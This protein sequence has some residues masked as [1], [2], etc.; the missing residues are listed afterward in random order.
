LKELDDQYQSRLKTLYSDSTTISQ[1]LE[2]ADLIIGAVLIPGKLAPKVLT[3]E[4][5]KKAA[6]GSVFVD[7]AI[8]QGGCS[9][10]SRPTTHSNPTYVEEGVVHYCVANMPGACARTATLALTHATYKYAC[11]IANKGY[12]EALLRH[13]GLMEGLNVCEGKVTNQPVAQDLGHHYY[14]PKECLA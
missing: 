1:L 13:P 7:V 11:D 10:T 14:Q 8:D 12:K 5:L 4:M 3:R 6:P 9:E 2:D